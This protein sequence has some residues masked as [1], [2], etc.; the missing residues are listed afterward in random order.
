LKF[1]GYFSIFLPIL[2]IIIII[3]G[4]FWYLNNRKITKELQDLKEENKN[5][6]EGNEQLKIQMKIVPI[7]LIRLSSVM[8]TMIIVII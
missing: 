1:L 2:S 5:L 6:K 3:V 8:M 7:N 4:A